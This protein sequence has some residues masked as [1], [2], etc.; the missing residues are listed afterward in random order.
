MK[1]RKRNEIARDLNDKLNDYKKLKSATG[2]TLD[3]I[4]GGCLMH[5]GNM[6]Y[7]RKISVWTG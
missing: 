5:L 6:R 3:I 4:N 2:F 7:K 1:R